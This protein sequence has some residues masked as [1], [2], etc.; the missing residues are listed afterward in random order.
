MYISNTQE[1]NTISLL[2]NQSLGFLG[3]ISSIFAWKIG[4]LD[5]CRWYPESSYQ[6]ALLHAPAQIQLS[7]ISLA[8]N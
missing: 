5:H 8:M 2:S 3:R 7:L 1:P 6:Q 4:D